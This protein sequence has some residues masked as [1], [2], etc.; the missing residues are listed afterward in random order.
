MSIILNVVSIVKKE[1]TPLK[2]ELKY[3][4]VIL[5]VVCIAILYFLSTLSQ[6][7][8]IELHE[9]PD[10]EG[11]Q[12]IVEG[13]VTEHHVTTYGGHIINIK[14]MDNQSNFEIIVFVEEKTTVEYG[15]RIQATGKVQKYNDEWEIVVNDA[16]FVKILQKWSNITFPLWQLAENPRK[17][18]GINI[19][20]TGIVD[21][22]YDTYF[23]LV[24][25]EEQHSIVVYYDSS[26][27]HNFTQGD[28]V[29]V[30]GQ[31]IYDEET[32]RFTITVKDEN[33]RI[34]VV[35]TE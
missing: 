14:D 13:T 34:S 11:K 35:E 7:I 5:S 20:V 32:L 15:D 17:Y 6:P 24:D 8:T 29:C 2:M 30:R 16:R 9:V 21:R 28:S 27:F 18:V 4:V 19:N 25:S 22:D 23:Y 12:V 1:E 3:F 31:F 26:I 10:Y 33:H